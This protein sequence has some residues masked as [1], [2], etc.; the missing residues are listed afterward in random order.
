[1]KWRNTELLKRK[2]HDNAHLIRLEQNALIGPSHNFF[3]YLVFFFF[4]GKWQEVAI[5]N[6]PKL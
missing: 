2:K 3:L 5:T 1:M 4:L 6:V